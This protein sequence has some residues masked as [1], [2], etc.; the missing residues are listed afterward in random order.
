MICLN[1]RIILSPAILSDVIAGV[2]IKIEPTIGGHVGSQ[3]KKRLCFRTASLGQTRI[4]CEACRAK[5][6]LFILLRLNMAAV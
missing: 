1:W 3:G 4:Q 2:V 5:S 6:K